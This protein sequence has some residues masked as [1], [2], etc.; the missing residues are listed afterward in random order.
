MG[1]CVLRETIRKG[2]PR[3]AP[4]RFLYLS[5]YLGLCV[6]FFVFACVYFMCVSSRVGASYCRPSHLCV[7]RVGTPPAR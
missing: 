3:Y 4:G 7:C 6:C 1:S 2:R 5:I